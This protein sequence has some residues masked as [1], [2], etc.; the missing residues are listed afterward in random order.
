M[1]INME[2]RTL[3]NLPGEFFLDLLFVPT[4]KVLCSQRVKSDQ[5]LLF[6]GFEIRAKLPFIEGN[7]GF[8]VAVRTCGCGREE[9]DSGRSAE[10][11]AC[12]SKEFGL[13]L[14]RFPLR[15]QAGAVLVSGCTG[16]GDHSAVT[17]DRRSPKRF[18]Y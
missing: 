4:A 6:G 8:R 7:S 3:E 12:G 9:A 1:R 17:A 10:A 16:V 2:S 11:M 18:V 15:G 14:S 13:P 5:L